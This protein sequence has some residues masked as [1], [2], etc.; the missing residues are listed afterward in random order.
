VN[1]AFLSNPSWRRQFDAATER[2]LRPRPSDSDVA[3]FQLA[4]VQRTWADAVADIPYYSGLVASGAA[5]PVCRDWSDVACLPVLTRRQLQDRPAE[6]IRR[7]GPP[8]AFVSTAGSTGTPLRIGMNQAE[9]DHLRVVKVAA[10]Q[11]FGY[12]LSSR[13]FLIWGH[14]HLLGTGWRGRVNHWRRK[15]ADA[16]MGYQRVDA[17]RL[18]RASCEAHAEAMLRFRPLGVIGYASALDLFA[19]Y[20]SQYRDR[21]RA[22]G[23]HFVLS[24][25][26][27]PPRP[28][29]IATLQDLF[30]CPV[31]EEYGGAEFG[32]VAFRRQPQTFD[33][34]HDLNYVECEAAEGGS[35]ARPLLVTTLYSRYL[36]LI[37]YRPGDALLDPE[38]LPHRHV[39][40]FQA[41]AGRLNDVIHLA[42]GDAIHSVAVFH[43][44][45]EER[46]VQSIQM[47]LEDDGIVINLVAFGGD[48]P[49]IA[50]RV[51]ARLAQ[52]HPT[53]ANADVRFVEDQ[54]PSRAGKRRWYVDRRTTTSCVASPAS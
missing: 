51:R 34:Y 47:V 14:A 49:A 17:Y 10:W 24:T 53:L 20:T 19:R 6:F 27:A 39:A 30:G 41:V 9:R 44:I 4:A 3:R 50:S 38:L 31:V 22:L 43:C 5:P 33:V 42:S 7:S 48:H 32:Q 37:R 26:E 52:V 2:R 35:D 21:F 8:D 23:V 40:R 1:A 16:L 13:L 36:P 18:N 11:D 25:A 12:T 54:L 15:A 46:D 29:T 45:H 28:D